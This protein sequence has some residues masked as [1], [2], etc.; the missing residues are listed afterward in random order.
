MTVEIPTNAL[1]GA[2][3]AEGLAIGVEE[4]DGLGRTPRGDVQQS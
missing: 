4:R 1:I 3:A 2:L